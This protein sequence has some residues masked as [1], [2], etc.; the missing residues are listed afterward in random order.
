MPAGLGQSRRTPVLGAAKL[1]GLHIKR[2]MLGEPAPIRIGCHGSKR[3][4]RSFAKSSTASYPFMHF[5]MSIAKRKA[6]GKSA[7][8]S[9]KLGRRSTALSLP[10]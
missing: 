4:G 3:K 10:G 5:A 7:A 9:S 1:S 8:E 2:G 6:A